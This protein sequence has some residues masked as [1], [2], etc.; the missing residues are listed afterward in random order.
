MRQYLSQ[1]P[2]DFISETARQGHKRHG[3]NPARSSRINWLRS[4]RAEI[5][6]LPFVFF[7]LFCGYSFS[8]IPIAQSFHR[9]K[10]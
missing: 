6:A 3:S 5:F 9:T 1:T 2:P 4:Y 8:A 7:A 10:L